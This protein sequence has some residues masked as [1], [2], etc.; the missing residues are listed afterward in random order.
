VVSR[1]TLSCNA[2]L[3]LRSIVSGR[4]DAEIWTSW[5]RHRHAS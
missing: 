4:G 5:Y 3:V 1:E 2:F